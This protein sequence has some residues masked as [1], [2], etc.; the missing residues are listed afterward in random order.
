VQQ[1]VGVATEPVL[2]PAGPEG[3]VEAAAEAGLVVLGLPDEWR[4][5]GAGAA[6][7]AIAVRAPVPV[8][9]VRRGPRPGGMTPTESLTRFTW[10][11]GSGGPSA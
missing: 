2:A 11:L 10:S 6:R 4:Q 9:L 8:V 5:D 1:L 3:V 7:A